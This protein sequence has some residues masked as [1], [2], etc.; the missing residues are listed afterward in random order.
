MTIQAVRTQPCILSKEQL[1]RIEAKL[2]SLANPM[3]SND[4]SQLIAGQKL[5]VQSVL[6]LL[7]E[8]WG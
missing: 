3:V 8:G 1:E 2:G 4:T 7:R 5:G 6:K